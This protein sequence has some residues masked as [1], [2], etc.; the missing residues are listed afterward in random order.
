MAH[1]SCPLCGDFKDCS[2]VLCE[3]CIDMLD[4]CMLS[5]YPQLRE[6]D[7][8]EAEDTAV[9]LY[10]GIVKQALRLYKFQGLKILSRSFCE[11]ID[12]EL[13]RR[14][15]SEKP[16]LIPV[17]CSTGRTLTQGWDQMSL[18]AEHLANRGCLVRSIISRKDLGSSQKERNRE[19]RLQKEY[20]RFSLDTVDLSEIRHRPCCILDDVRTTGATISE[21]RSLLEEA[22][23]TEVGSLALAM[24]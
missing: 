22:G 2:D 3:H 7:P 14:Y 6:F 20:D 10:Q 1:H 16:I 12:R 13:C 11:Y 17:P 9:F 5:G 19:E 18:I 21:C 8:H 24:D 15:L 4:A 23:F